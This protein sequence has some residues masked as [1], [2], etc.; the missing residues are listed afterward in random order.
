MK[1]RTLIIILCLVW[2]G[3]H[4]LAFTSIFSIASSMRWKRPNVTDRLRKSTHSAKRQY[5][6]CVIYS[7]QY[8]IW[9]NRDV[10]AERWYVFVVVFYSFV[11]H[12]ARWQMTRRFNFLF[13][14]CNRQSNTEYTI[15]IVN[16][17]QSEWQ[18]TRVSTEHHSL[19]C[20]LS[21][22]CVCVK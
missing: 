18:R 2:A 11:W 10:N 19:F 1:K 6:L 16:I 7:T 9:L 3:A 5:I 8:I 4:A 21:V 20:S 22:C 13:I 17:V 15:I 14:L 12:S